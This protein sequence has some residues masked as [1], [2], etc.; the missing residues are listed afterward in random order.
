MIDIK[1]HLKRAK[2]YILHQK[3]LNSKLIKILRTAQKNTK[4]PEN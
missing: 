2:K 3:Y 1:E 4:Q